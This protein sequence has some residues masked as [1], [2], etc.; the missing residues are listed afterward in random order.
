MREAHLETKRGSEEREGVVD[1]VAVPDE[2][3]DESVEP[4]EPLA[5]RE[6][7]RQRLAGMLPDR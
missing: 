1:V 3:E 6:H 5:E 2:G 7:V 4:P